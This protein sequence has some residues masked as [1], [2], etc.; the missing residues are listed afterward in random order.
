[1]GSYVRRNATSLIALM[2]VPLLTVLP[3]LSDPS[4][5][6]DPPH[7][8]VHA[9]TLLRGFER[10]TA[11][12]QDAL[13]LPLYQYVG[14][15][16]GNMETEKLTL[17]VYGWG[18][19]DIV[20]S[21]FYTD[22]PDGD[23]LY[24]YAQLALADNALHLKFGRQPV[25]SATSNETVDGVVV[26]GGLS[27]HIAL[28]AYGGLLPGYE[29]EVFS[30]EA[31]LYGGRVGFFWESL[32][33]MGF[34][35]KSIHG[36]GMTVDERMAMDLSWNPSPRFSF[37]GLSQ[38]NMETNG[39]AEHAYDARLYFSSF[40][41]HPYVQRFEYDDLFSGT[42]KTFN[43]FSALSE[44]DEILTRTGGEIVWRGL[45]R[46]DLGAKLENYAHDTT[47][48]DALYGSGFLTLH[49]GKGSQ[50]GG[51]IGVME[52][53]Q[54]EDRYQLGRLWFNC[55]NPFKAVRT[56]FITGDAV[57]VAY[58]EKVF[59]EDTS[60]FLSL[61]IGRS[62]LNEA[63]SLKLSGD[64]SADPYFDS[65]SRIMVTLAYNLNP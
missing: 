39:W 16:V 63:L 44:T 64:Y 55:D 18:R 34:S 47:A 32:W 48:R 29:D 51:E 5:Y 22:D 35:Y 42:P 7:V 12:E 8:S 37:S 65:D 36:N 62:F 21:D 17:H 40:I 46:A 25:V 15:D 53:D 26:E 59:E 27:R 45:A 14:L 19:K 54:N 23:L 60:L 61:G 58:K 13:V 57:Y 1:M 43:P 38:Y 6:A 30:S 33:D 10:N 56:D 28:A 50:V 41:L 11:D 4:A 31:S 49:V 20:A 24:G 9:Q 2:W 52:G 3:S